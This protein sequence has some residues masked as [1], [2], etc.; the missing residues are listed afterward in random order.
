MT[1]C[2]SAEPSSEGGVPTA[3]T[4]ISP[5]ATLAATSVE[6]MRRPACSLRLTIGSS[7]GS[8]IGISPALRRAIFFSS[9]SRQNTVLPA[10][11]R[12]APVTRPTYPVPMTVTFMPSTLCESWCQLELLGSPRRIGFPPAAGGTAPVELPCLEA[13]GL[14][15][16]AREAPRVAVHQAAHQLEVA[17]LAR[18]AGADDLR[19]EQA[20]ETEQG[21]VAPQLVA[22]QLVGLIR[23][24]RFQRQLEHGVEQV[25]RR[26]AL[27]VAG[28]QAHAFVGAAGLAVR[29]RQPL[30]RQREVGGILGFDALPLL[31]RLLR[32]AARFLQVAQLQAGAH[33]FAVLVERRLGLRRGL[34]GGQLAMVL[35]HLPRPGAVRTD[36][37]RHRQR[38]RPVLFQLVDFKQMT[39]RRARV[40]GR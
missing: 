21:R 11:A 13:A 18:R 38:P 31:D 10:S 4:W 22:H 12:Q 33:A 19:L 5:C 3:M 34:R 6:N 20:V 28:E 9:R 30:R 7:P 36:L 17:P 37:A 35:R 23:A 15:A 26:I 8:K 16:V 32:V 2:M 29:L 1:C 14:A 39:A 24:L 40:A 25:E 27:Q